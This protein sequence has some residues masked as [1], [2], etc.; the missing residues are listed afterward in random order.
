MPEPAVGLSC[1]VVPRPG[2]VNRAM[3][4]YGEFEKRYKDGRTYPEV[5]KC[6]E[7]GHRFDASRL[8]KGGIDRTIETE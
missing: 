7:L 3:S 1:Q 5:K 4:Y 2:Q 6:I 8:N